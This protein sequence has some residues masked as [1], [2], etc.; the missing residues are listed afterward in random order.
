MFII[1]CKDRG[2]NENTQINLVFL[3][4]QNKELFCIFAA[5]INSLTN[6]AR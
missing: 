1:C 6:Y 5:E 4:L 3:H 2:K